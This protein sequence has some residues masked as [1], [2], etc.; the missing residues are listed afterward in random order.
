[1]VEGVR[2][3]STQHDLWHAPPLFV[4]TASVTQQ[5]RRGEGGEGTRRDRMGREGV[6]EGREWEGSRGE[7]KEEEERAWDGTGERK[8][9]TEGEGNIW[10]E[11]GDVVCAR[12]VAEADTEAPT[13]APNQSHVAFL[14]TIHV[15]YE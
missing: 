2:A 7:G 4:I 12:G 3:T 15:C 11:A 14:Q 5:E 9:G 8:L 10:L 13:L 6:S 1:M